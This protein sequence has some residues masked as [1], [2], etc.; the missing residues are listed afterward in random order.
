MSDYLQQYLRPLAQQNYLQRSFEE[1]L[2]PQ[3]MFLA[4][5]PAQRMEPGSGGSMTATV[6]GNMAI[7]LNPVIPGEDAKTQT[8]SYEWYICNVEQR[9]GSQK[10]PMNQASLTATGGRGFWIQ[11]MRELAIQCGT[12]LNLLA[13]NELYKAYLQ[14]NTMTFA[15]TANATSVYLVSGNGFR[16]RVVAA[17]V[18]PL[19]STV[20]RTVYIDGQERT[21]TGWTPLIAEWP[22]GP[23]ILTVSANVTV[24]ANR[25]VL[26][27][28]RSIIIRPSSTPFD[29]LQAND[30][31]TMSLFRRAVADLENDGVQAME[32]GYFHCHISPHV[33]D[34]LMSD[35]E[36]QRMYEGAP[37]KFMKDG[38]LG[39][40]GKMKFFS[41][42]QTPQPGDYNSPNPYA[43]GGIVLPVASSRN[44]L[45]DRWYYGELY[46]TLGTQI[47]RSIVIGRGTIKTRFED[48]SAMMLAEASAPIGSP[49][50]FAVVGNTLQM[51]AG[52]QNLGNVRITVR[53]PIDKLGQ[54]TDI[55][56]S[57]TRGFAVTSNLL[58]GQSNAQ[59]KRAK[60]IE[61]GF[62]PSG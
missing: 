59:N 34:Q 40:I 54:V 49:T 62:A 39:V 5:A 57:T 43:V 6:P 14:G 55:T 51:M 27:K 37:E 25:P 46:N 8:N 18:A 7:D 35:N 33:S 41:N 28:N 53:P 4:C 31:A 38:A 9:S 61:T 60:V 48:E 21:A 24:A 22:D 36:Y 56:W 50:T 58:S 11:K 44:T 23:G 17:K 3:V 20:T 30:I 16:D 42:N 32:D 12:T 15:A 26:D 29:Q 1:A 47:Q 45:L 2:V 10:I 19:T 52:S 13:R